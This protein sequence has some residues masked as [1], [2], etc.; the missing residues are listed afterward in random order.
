[1]TDDR[2]IDRRELQGMVSLKEI[3]EPYVQLTK[4]GKDWV[5]LC[6]FHAERTPSFNVVED[7]GFFICFGCNKTGDG[8][9]FLIDHCGMPFPEALKVVEAKAGIGEMPKGYKPA[10]KP[11][12]PAPAPGEVQRKASAIAWARKT[13]EMS[14]PSSGTL[15][16]TYLT[17]RAIDI[18]LIGG[19]PHTI[20]YNP[21]L[22]HTE[23]GRDWPAMVAAIQNEHG[24]IIG[25]HRTYI[26]YAPAEKHPAMHAAFLALTGRTSQCDHVVAKAPVKRQKKMAGM[27]K[28]GAIRLAPA[29]ETLYIAEGIETALSVMQAMEAPA[30]AAMSLGNM[31]GIKLPPVVREVV[32]CADNDAKDPDAAE[33]LLQAAAAE[34]RKQEVEVRIARPPSGKDFN[35]VLMARYRVAEAVNAG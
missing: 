8:I 31:G 13:W 29:G 4:Q 34:Y 11:R 3:I 14:V 19:M 16:E 23:D 35:D 7:K 18:P 9:K 10:P 6:P 21:A 12:P 5:G 32:L 30:W 1:M 27:S 24:E 22:R 25:I 2:R 17:C 33:K 28:G 26:A 20:R 15:A